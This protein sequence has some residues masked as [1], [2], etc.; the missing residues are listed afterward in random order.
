MVLGTIVEKHSENY[1]LDIGTAIPARLP[2]LAFEGA[3]KR[4][5]PNLQV[6]ELVYA[7]VALSDKHM[8]AEL[9]CTS[10]HFKKDWVTGESIFGPVKGGY[11]MS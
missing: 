10:P 8:E 1:R 3:T 5:K 9:T 4:N 2:A 11:G 7:R 6:G